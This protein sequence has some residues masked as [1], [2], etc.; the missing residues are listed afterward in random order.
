VW[1]LFYILKWT[2][3]QNFNFS[4]SQL[5][6]CLKFNVVGDCET[7]EI[8]IKEISSAN[9]SN[10]LN[11]KWIRKEVII[12]RTFLTSRLQSRT[13]RFTLLTC[14]FQTTQT[15]FSW[16]IRKLDFL[17]WG[18]VSPLLS[19]EVSKR[20]GAESRLVRRVYGGWSTG[21]ERCWASGDCRQPGDDVIPG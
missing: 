12:L 8:L 17:R 14:Q 13:S 3:L 18:R 16:S 15:S 7:G 19:L 5:Q 10:D 4:E 6:K 1:Y 21:G 20:K 9:S 11:K 2:F